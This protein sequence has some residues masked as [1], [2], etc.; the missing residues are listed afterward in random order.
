[1]GGGRYWCRPRNHPKK[2][3]N[4]QPLLGRLLLPPPARQILQGRHQYRPPP[5]QSQ[6]CPIIYWIASLQLRKDVQ[7]HSHTGRLCQSPVHYPEEW[8]QGGIDHTRPHWP[9][10]RVSSGGYV[11]PIGIPT[12]QRRHRLDTYLKF[13]KVQQVPTYL[14]KQNHV[15]HKSCRPSIGSIG[16]IH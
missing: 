15:C 9:H 11:L 3:R 13:Q 10:Q 1:M 16:R 4:Q 7:S 14:W 5:V 2:Y 12:T 6:G 8:S